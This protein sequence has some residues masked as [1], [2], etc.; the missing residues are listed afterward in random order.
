MGY[1]KI[2]ELA[3]HT[4]TNNETLRF[5]ESKGLLEPPRRT[6]AGYRLY[7]PMDVARVRFIVRARRMGFSLKEIDELLS[8]RVDREHSTCG[9]VKELAET[10]LE[11]IDRRLAELEQMKLALQRITDACCGGEESAVHCTIL[12]ALDEEAGDEAPAA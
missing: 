8:L 10:K 2:G 5:Y 4:G 12:N 3:R 6:E 11:D 7:A 9:E 1:L